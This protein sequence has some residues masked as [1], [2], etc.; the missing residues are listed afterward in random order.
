[1]LE[2][3][4]SHLGHNNKYFSKVLFYGINLNVHMFIFSIVLSIQGLGHLLDS[5]AYTF[6]MGRFSKL[7]MKN[8]FYEVFLKSLFLLLGSK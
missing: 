6:M 5:R 3:V 4:L 2:T 8:E 1:M 7:R